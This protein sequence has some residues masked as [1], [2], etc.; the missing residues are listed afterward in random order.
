VTDVPQPPAGSA[1]LREDMPG[2]VRL[3]WPGPSG[4]RGTIITVAL[5]LLGV[6][7]V[8]GML[9][10]LLAG[11][12]F[13]EG[14]RFEIARYVV[15]AALVVAASFLATVL[16]FRLRALFRE[17]VVL[18][19]DALMWF[20]PA[21]ASHLSGHLGWGG[22]GTMYGH[23]GR[24][25]RG[26]FHTVVEAFSLW[27]QRESIRIPRLTITDL[28]LE[29]KGRF[30]HLTISIGEGGVDVAKGLGHEDREWLLGQLRSWREASG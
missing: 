9:G 21:R 26:L 20:P 13:R 16:A 18:K 4:A 7:V 14:T 2:G 6:A 27:R 8:V 17:A 29:G 25:A 24:V 22:G 5:A 1:I 28:G 15:M 10:M 11:M 23:S 12:V 3:S 19:T 30:E